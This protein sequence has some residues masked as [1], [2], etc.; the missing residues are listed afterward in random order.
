[1]SVS[2]L[3]S[4]FLDPGAVRFGATASFSIFAGDQELTL[5]TG[6]VFG[7]EPAALAFDLNVKQYLGD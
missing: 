5:S 1:M 4:T 7:P 3:G 2:L 6:G